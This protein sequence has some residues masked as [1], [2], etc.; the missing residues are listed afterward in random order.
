MDAFAQNLDPNSLVVVEAVLS[1]A[2]SPFTAP[3]Y[4]LPLFLF[5]AYAQENSDSNQSLKLFTGL[6]GGSMLMDIIW[7]IRN[8]QNWFIRLLSVLIL[9]FKAPTFFAFLSAL[10][11]R[12]EQFSG[13]GVRGGDLSGP[14]VWSMPG[15]FSGLGGGRNGY[16]SVD[17]RDVEAHPAPASTAPAHTQTPAVPATPSA[18]VAP[19]G[20]Q[21]T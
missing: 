16:D 20:Y 15:G 14:T 18:P 12:G 6:L 5:G 13:L 7:L 17:D 10:R 21:A 19:G 8:E 2:V 3:S 4:N 9:I 11:Q 1:F